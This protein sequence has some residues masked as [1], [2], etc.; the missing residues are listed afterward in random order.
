MHPA[1]IG[2]IEFGSTARNDA[3]QHSDKDIFAVVEDADADVLDELRALVATEYGTVP[4]SVAC[5]SSSSFDQMIAR[6]SLF[7][8][9]LRLEGRILSDPDD[10][11]SEAF[12]NLCRYAA[13]ETDLARFKDIYT[14]TLEAFM[15]AST[16]DMFERHVLFVVARNVCML[17]TARRNRP[18][19]GRRTV[20]PAA[21]QLYPE[22]PL[23]A[24]VA[25]TLEIGHLT[26]VRNLHICERQMGVADPESIFREVGALVAF[27]AEVLP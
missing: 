17:L 8:W 23:S 25:E 6:G 14:D 18:T 26:Y 1:I 19:F 21:R 22:L 5:Y 7:T 12:E 10:I 11:F 4:S 15:Y 27:A 20:I 16:L 2:I 3:D 9:H 13:F 24:S